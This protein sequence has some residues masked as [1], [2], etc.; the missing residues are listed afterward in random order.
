MPI[1]RFLSIKMA[2]IFLEM[3]DPRI[4]LMSRF[5]VSITRLSVNFFCQFSLDE[6]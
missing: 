1:Q 6:V 3:F 2:K 4:R 5:G